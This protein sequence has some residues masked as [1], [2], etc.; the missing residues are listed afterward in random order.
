MKNPSDRT[1][2]SCSSGYSS[3]MI[4]MVPESVKTVLKETSE[5]T[6]KSSLKSSIYV[7]FQWDKNLQ[8]INYA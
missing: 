4:Y 5:C 3:H 1:P 7:S 6:N 8:N 2:I